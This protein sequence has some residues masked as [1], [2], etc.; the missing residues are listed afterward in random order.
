MSI[1]RSRSAAQS[2]EVEQ[3]HAA[4][5]EDYSRHNSPENRA[6][7]REQSGHARSHGNAAAGAW[8]GR[9]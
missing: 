2:S 9:K 4:A 3:L 8:R 1:F 7:A 5:R 6:A